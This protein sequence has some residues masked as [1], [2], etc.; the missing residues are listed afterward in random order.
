MKQ[1]ILLLIVCCTCLALDSN[2]QS[3][4]KF[5]VYEHFTN[6]SCPPCAARNPTFIKNFNENKSHALHIG[7]HTAFPGFDPM[8][9][10]NPDPVNTRQ[11]YYSVS[12][13]PFFI[14]NAQDSSEEA[15]ESVVNQAKAQTSPVKLTVSNDIINGKGNCK[16]I[17]DPLSEIET[18][19]WKLRVAIVEK[20][21]T[22]SSPPGSNG[23]K[24][25]PNVFREMVPSTGGQDMEFT[26]ELASQEFTFE[27]DINSD[28]D[29]RNLYAI[30]FLQDDNTK[31]ILNG[32]SSLELQAALEVADD[33]NVFKTSKEETITLEA[34]LQTLFKNETNLTIEVETN[35]PE[36]WVAN[37]VID[38][39]EIEGLSYSENFAGNVTNAIGVNITPGDSKAFAKY[40]LKV[41]GRVAPKDSGIEYDFFVNNGV[42]T[43]ILYNNDIYNENYADPL[44]DISLLD[45]LG[46][47]PRK[48][49]KQA[50][51]DKQLDEVKHIYYNTG[52]IF[53]AID[54]ET[55]NLLTGFLAG[56]GNL[57]LTGQDIAWDALSDEERSHRSP[58][59]TAFFED[60]LHVGYANNGIGR[61]NL[62]VRPIVEEEIYGGLE[63]FDYS[64]IVLRGGE[65]SPDEI[66][67]LD[68]NA[69]P[70]LQ[71]GGAGSILYDDRFAGVR[72]DNGLY[73]IVYL[74][75]SLQMMGTE[76]FRN[77]FMRLTHQYFS[78][79]ITSNE[80]DTAIKGLQV[81]Q[82]F[83]NP[84]GNFTTINLENVPEAMNLRLMDITGKE[85]ATYQVA[86][87]SQQLTIPTNN[88]NQGTYIY[89]LTNNNGK[90]IRAKKM[91]IVH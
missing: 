61:S 76:D 6:A 25:F 37:L 52:A 16:V 75:L 87:G 80:Y 44:L 2:A 19:N 54:D 24:E 64:R 58:V 18:G 79:F 28:W 71:Y 78:G 40:T 56:G 32:G 41:R 84:A 5:V 7:Y 65:L 67:P 26:A 36:D 45:G 1:F 48:V 50:M 60:Y 9:T 85:I 81:H 21:V 72:I 11:D 29:H 34:S 74:G 15:V 88:I 73:K 90:V 43:I 42:E 53:P 77:E 46:M 12:G 13:V 55:A 14:A 68:E 89:Q 23:E 10:L 91:T 8:Y 82:N 30:A 31:E 17:V 86:A 70:I 4:K 59:T 63:D 51:N 38:N 83:P 3:A 47:I 69:I 35:A 20:L 39:E 57:L 49:Y 27:Y 22:Y 66:V 62:K 33:Q